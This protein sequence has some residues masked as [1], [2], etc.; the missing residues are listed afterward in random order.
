MA[1]AKVRMPINAF[2]GDDELEVSFPGNWDVRE[3]RM[4]GHDRPAL[5]D[6]QM[7]QALANPIG[8]PRL[9]ERARGAQKVCILFDDIPKPTPV[10]R[11]APFV[12]EELHA[13]A[14]KDEQI[15]FVCAP[16]T[17]RPLTIY[18][19]MAAKIG[20]AI[21]E[22]Y[23]VYNHTIWENTVFVGTT[24]RGTPI[25][26][27]RE[28][29]SCDLRIGIGCVIPHSRAGFGG[30]GKLVV[31]GVS[32]IET[33]A[34]H[35][36]AEHE[37]ASRGNV[38]GNTFRL[39]IEEGA[40]LAGLHFKADAVLNNRRQVVG[41]FAGDFVAEHR[42]AVGLARQVYPTPMLKDADVVVTNSYPD[43]SQPYRGIWCVA[44]SLKEGGDVVLVAHS[45]VGQNLHQLGSR[46]GSDYGGRGFRHRPGAVY[47][48]L[49]KAAR[50]LFLSPE[51][52][53]YERDGF[54]P[55]DKLVWCKDWAQVLAE[56]AAR[57]GVGTKVAVYPYATIQL[58]A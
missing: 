36:R 53:K 13:G 6:E 29:H 51:M 23:T 31:P 42:A 56:L 24:S 52:S 40:R 12:L 21:L 4:A 48:G 19:E 58:P 1:Q 35:H 11:I 37:N 57:H 28:F 50:I 2:F 34:H 44:R 20:K 30:G 27:N 10:D 5:S 32:G 47:P 49:E 17:H 41:L 26:V 43:E 16:G 7:R 45:K 33:I 14:V 55:Q 25:H 54:G 22:R 46:F 18:P 38:D 39:D 9:R 3:C 15:R 8:S